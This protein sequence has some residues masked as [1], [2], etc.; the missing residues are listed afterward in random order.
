MMVGFK[1]KGWQVEPIVG[2]DKGELR[3]LDISPK[4]AILKKNLQN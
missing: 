4:T 3:L 2:A 1:M